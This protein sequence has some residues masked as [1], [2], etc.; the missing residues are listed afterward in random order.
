MPYI[1]NSPANNVRGRF[2][3]TASA[4]QTLFSGADIN[5]K[6]L[7][8]Q[9]GGYV[10]VY[11]N[12]VLLQDTIDYTATTKT[13][14]NL[15]SGAT[16]GDL[17]EIVA[18]GI[19]SVADTVSALSGGTFEGA[20]V[21]NNNFTVDNGTIKLD[22]NYPTGTGNVAL[23]DTALDSVT[24][25]G[26]YNTA[27][28]RNVLT[29]TTSGQQ[30]TAVGNSGLAGNTTG[31]F[32]DAFGST[33]L[34]SNTSGNYNVALG[35]N[36]LRS[37]TTADNNI[38]VGYQAGYSNTTGTA[39]VLV[40]LTT[41]YNITT[42]PANVAVGNA[43]LYNTT[44]GEYNSVLGHA[45]LYSNSTGS[46]NV[47]MGRSALGNNTT[48]SN[49]TAV[50]YQAG[51]SGTTSAANTL[52]G[53]QAGYSLTTANGNTFIGADS[54]DTVTTG[55][56]NTIIGRYN[57]NQGGLDIRTSSNNIVLSE[58]DG[59]PRLW[60]TS[61]FLACPFVYNVTTAST[62]N[63]FVDAAGGIYRG[64][65]SALKYKQDIR[66]LEKIDINL[67]RPVRYK[68]NCEVDD[69][70][71]DY[72]GVVADEVADAGIEELVTRN[73]NGE[74]ESFQYDRLTVVLLKAIQEQQATIEALE[75]RIAALETP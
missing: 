69:Q 70:T 46:Y 25:G 32:N 19:F 40:G 54:G 42:A 48:A 51:Y 45:A 5:G 47:A 20:V 43:T 66:D 68:S 24:T 75:A 3:Y 56:N 22:G 64:G 65:V 14:I 26:D 38:A 8:Y 15:V 71:K 33:A 57:G 16:A 44:T 49:N 61:S 60:L 63:V 6:T 4:A 67:I 27:V 9:D 2:Y 52:I 23:G 41:G 35:S 73:D 37:N 13:S 34:L 30:N 74:V 7:A 55:Q 11:L 17:V 53:K 10:D 72:F 12:G 58:G 28:G 21:V 59:N 18:Y 1:G 36:A 62:P 39:N 29:A 50:G 31:S